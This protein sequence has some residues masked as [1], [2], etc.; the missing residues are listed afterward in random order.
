MCTVLL[1]T[2]ALQRVIECSAAGRTGGACLPSSGP[3]E[4]ITLRS[5]H[6]PA[7]MHC[8]LR[9]TQSHCGKEVRYLGSHFEIKQDFGRFCFA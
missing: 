5:K 2:L 9:V 7:V 6:V 1:G 3:S 4:N 8:R